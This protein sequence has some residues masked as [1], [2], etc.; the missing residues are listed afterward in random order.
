[1]KISINKAENLKS[2]PDESNLGFGQY[3]SDHMFTM[4]YIDGEWSNAQILPY[5]DISISPAT[6]VLHYGQAI[7]EGMKAYK[8]ADEGIY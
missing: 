7:F 1:M 4:D 5:Q 6:M 2:K 3:F 8:T